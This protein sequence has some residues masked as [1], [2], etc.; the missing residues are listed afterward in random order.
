MTHPTLY[1][2]TYLTENGDTS[3]LHFVADRD[4]K[5]TIKCL[6]KAYKTEYER[7]LSTTDI[8]GISAENIACD[9]KE[10]RDYRIILTP[11]KNDTDHISE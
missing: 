11:I 6:Q 2:G 4:E 10:P 1:I 8:Q 5:Y 9:Y 3:F 7:E